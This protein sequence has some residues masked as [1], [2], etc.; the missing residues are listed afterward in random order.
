[1]KKVGM[2]WFLVLFFVCSFAQTK[3]KT[4][5][6]SWETLQQHNIPEWFKD[7]KFGI[8][9]HLG[10]YCV[11]AFEGEWYPRY[12]YQDNHKVQKHH[13][14]TYG[15]LD[16]FGY[17]DFIPMFKLKNW[18]PKEWADLYKRAGA[19][20]AGPVAE[21]HDGFSMW[22][23]K[24]NRWNT[25]KMGPKRDVVGELVREIRKND[26]KVIT[27]FHH[28]F[29]I[30]GYYETVEGTHTADPKYADLYGKLPLE[31]SYERWFGKLKEVIDNYQPDQIWF[32]WGLRAIPMEYRQKFASYYYSK[33]KEWGKE[34]IITRKLDQLPKGVGVHDYES[35]SPRDLLPELWQTDQSTGGHYWSYRKGLKTKSSRWL[36]HELI[37]VVSKNGVMLLNVCPA[38]D[39]TIPGG[40]KEMLYEVG[41]WLKINGEAIYGTRPW[42]VAGEG[43]NM[44]G[45]NGYYMEYCSAPQS[46]TMNVHYTQ[47]DGNLYAICLDWP[48]EGFTFDKIQVK[49]KSNKAKITLLGSGEVDYS[50]ADEK[51]TIKK[52]GI[53]AG[54]LSF[55]H[56]YVFKIEGF[57]LKA[58]PFS[59]L[60]VLNL[61]GN[62]ATTT[63]HIQK[64]IVNPVDGKIQKN[65]LQNWHNAWDKAYWLVNVKVPG[66]YI[67]RGEL[68]TRFRAARM[69]LSNGEDALKFETEPR[70]K[71]G[72]SVIKD[73]GVI[74]FKKSGLYQIELKAQD[75]DNFPGIQ[76][77]WQI[78]LAPLD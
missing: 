3:D 18:N 9:A 35:G 57:D 26:M 38:A 77:F 32:D 56:A 75:F 72:E 51:L 29:N 76:R 12:M 24:I 4:I 34:V 49:G 45:K 42:R 68:A 14:E 62:N 47:K 40:Q 58:D 28:G 63:G 5:E 11:P 31:Q 70:T 67:V 69:V 19:K 55:K 60:E 10:V 25:K 46:N 15:S 16:K 30:D 52:L 36:L 8:Y 17:H 7:A 33:E 64:R 65:G 59:K 21:H 50:I 61:N 66:K 23:S 44:Y 39:G 78:E 13:I 1:M 48:G 20:F 73:Y 37:R 2:T 71:Y 6:M 53:K 54:D 43:P 27:S 74:T 22:G 41:D